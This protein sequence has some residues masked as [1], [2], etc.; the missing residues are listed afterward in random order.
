MHR[1]ERV[2]L[3]M[4]EEDDGYIGRTI[5]K[6]NGEL[7][8]I[9]DDQLPSFVTKQGDS[10]VRAFNNEPTDIA[11]FLQSDQNARAVV[12]TTSQFGWKGLS[13]TCTALFVEGQETSKE[14][15]AELVTNADTNVPTIVIGCE[16]SDIVYDIDEAYRLIEPPHMDYL[17]VSERKHTL[18]ENIPIR[19]PRAVSNIFHGQSISSIDRET[20]G[21]VGLF[22]SSADG[23]E[24]G[25]AL[26]AGHVLPGSD[27]SVITPGKLDILS[28]VQKILSKKKGLTEKAKFLLER[29]ENACG[30]LRIRHVGTNKNTWKSDWA[31]V[32]L[33]PGWKSRNGTWYDSEGVIDICRIA[34]R[35]PPSFTG[36]SGIVGIEEEPV[37]GTLCFKDGA[38][39]GT[40]VGVLGHYE[41]CIYRKGTAEVAS[42]PDESSEA[43]DRCRVLPI[44]Q[45]GNKVEFCDTGDS[46]SAVFCLDIEQNG[47]TW[48]GQLVSRLDI[49]G[50]GGSCGL[51]VP[52][53]EI[54][55]SLEE[56]TGK[57]WRL[58]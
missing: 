20:K 50:A 13:V 26:T 35:T 41:M 47:F 27:V 30:T 12:A 53:K 34:C 48:A 9:R 46:G 39:T 22:L 40:T 10:S 49:E 31:L 19:A 16:L 56:H 2:S 6:P 17:E 36:A 8:G 43:I 54:L 37:A 55:V 5:T 42:V 58:S 21:S 23:S 44:Y 32:E 45:A 28:E 51:M 52:Q 57:K 7:V 14:R 3:P 1:E 29:S 15:M 4:F 33:H 25:Y 38:R 24:E 11:S 18:R